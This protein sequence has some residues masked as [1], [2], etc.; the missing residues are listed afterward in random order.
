MFLT[1]MVSNLLIIAKQMTIF[2]FLIAL[3]K[4]CKLQK[5]NYLSLDR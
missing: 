1:Q 3:F 5:A 2:N 4:F